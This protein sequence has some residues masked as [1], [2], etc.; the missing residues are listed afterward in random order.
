MTFPSRIEVEDLRNDPNNK[1]ERQGI[2]EKD[3]I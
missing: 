1:E 3:K 2:S